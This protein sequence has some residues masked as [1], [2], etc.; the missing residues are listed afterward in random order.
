M[1]T[2]LLGDAAQYQL[3]FDSQIVEMNA[4]VGQHIELTFNQTI[5]CSNC[6]R[7]TPKSYS[8]GFCFPC[9]RSLARCDLCI[10][11]PETCHFHLG[12]CR[13]PEW[14]EAHCFAPHIIYLANSSGLKVGITRK[15]NM[16]SRWIDQGAIGAIPILE[17]STRLE[18][19]RVEVALKEHVSDKTNWRKM[20]KNETENIDL[21][22][23]KNTLLA[24]I[25]KLIDELGATRLNDDVVNI[26]YP[27]L[28]YPSKI[29]S[30]NFDKTP[31]IS[32]VLKGI[33]GQYLLLE[34]GVLNIRKFGSYHV[35]LST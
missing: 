34:N 25:P 23:A 18:S 12:T 13:E 19:G 30:L 17:V 3:A 9:A 11:R 5:Q 4:L 31:V 6:S 1:E 15:T 14:G 24:G 20:L 32:G 29:S 22:E 33:K 35:T 2:S 7:V 21:V 10:M 27:V 16:P 28:Q 26:D 8:Q